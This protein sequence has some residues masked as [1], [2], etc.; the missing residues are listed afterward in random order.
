MLFEKCF[1]LDMGFVF[2]GWCGVG[3]G[4]GVGCVVFSFVVCVCVLWVLGLFWW[5]CGCVLCLLCCGVV[6]FGGGGFVG[7]FVGLGGVLLCV[8]VLIQVAMDRFTALFT[9]GFR[10]R[11]FDTLCGIRQGSS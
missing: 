2:A 5:W 11:C 7:V 8:F 1:C 6:C 9:M 4:G 3:V 10:L